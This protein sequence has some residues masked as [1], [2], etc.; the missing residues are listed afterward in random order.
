MNVIANAVE[1]SAKNGK[2]LFKVQGTKKTC[3]F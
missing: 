3:S 2:L 1:Y